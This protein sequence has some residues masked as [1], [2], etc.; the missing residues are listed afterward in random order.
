STLSALT[1]DT[2]AGDDALTVD[3]TNGS[4]LPATGLTF[5]GGT[6]SGIGDVLNVIGSGAADAMTIDASHI[7]RG[8]ASISYGGVEQLNTQ[9]GNFAISADLSGLAL[10]AGA[11][12]AV[13][14]QTAQHLSPLAIS[15]SG[16]AA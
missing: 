4:P 10:S 3:F 6:Q 13:N 15:G 16:S 1:V 7:S 14:F 2:G 12:A 5:T 8:A 9:S 11:G